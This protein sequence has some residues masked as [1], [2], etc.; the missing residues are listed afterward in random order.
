MKSYTELRKQ[1]EEFRKRLV[2]LIVNRD[3]N[4]EI[5]PNEIPSADEREVLR[6][7]YYIK[8]G[9]DTIHVAPLDTKVLNR[10]NLT[11]IRCPQFTS[12]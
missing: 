7:Y 2:D 6:Y 10:V 5:N 8:Y 12:M 1:R 9:V 11:K 4:A 3:E